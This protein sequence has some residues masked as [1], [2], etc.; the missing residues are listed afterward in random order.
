[1]NHH[2][3]PSC[4]LGVFDI[5]TKAVFTLLL[6]ITQTQPFLSCQQNLGYNV[7]AHPVKSLSNLSPFPTSDVEHDAAGAAV[8]PEEADA[9]Q[10]EVD[11][12]E[13]EGHGGGQ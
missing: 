13:A 11:G 7:M 1:M 10:E 9:P 12:E 2:V 3:V 5:K 6:I 4:S 8:Q